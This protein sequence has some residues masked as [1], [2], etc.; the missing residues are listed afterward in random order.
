MMELAQKCLEN[1]GPTIL[2]FSLIYLPEAD[3]SMGEIMV[4]WN[5]Q[6]AV[7]STGK[8]LGWQYPGFQLVLAV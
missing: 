8:C 3:S 1:G 4:M 2:V 5:A 7:S 6:M